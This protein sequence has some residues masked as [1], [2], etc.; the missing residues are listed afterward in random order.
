MDNSIKQNIVLID[1]FSMTSK[2]LSVDNIKCLLGLECVDWEEGN[3]AHGF[4]HSVYFHS[5]KIFYNVSCAGDLF[6]SS[7]PDTILSKDQSYLVWL[8][9]SGS[10]C[11][12]FETFGNGD[13]DGLFRF[14]LSKPEDINI[15]RLDVAFDD[16]T[17]L[18]DI[19]DL[20]DHVDAHY[21]V[22]KFRTGIVEYEWDRLK[23]RDY[24]AFTL[25][26][27]SE[28]S[29]VRIRIYDK[30]KERNI[31]DEHWIRVEMQLRHD[32]AAGFL[33]ELVGHE[34]GLIFRGVLAEYLRFVEPE[35]DSNMRRWPTLSAWDQLL[36]GVAAIN[37][38]VKPG[39]EYNMERLVHFSVDM[40]GGATYTLIK[41]IGVSAFL[42]RLANRVAGADLNPNYKQLLD[43]LGVPAGS[44]DEWQ[45]EIALLRAANGRRRIN[46][47]VFN[48]QREALEIRSADLDQREAELNEAQLLLDHWLPLA[49][50]LSQQNDREG[51]TF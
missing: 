9:M 18:L 6:S 32:N 41:A 28:K 35:A 47:S 10:G 42:D 27:G 38:F 14:C 17:G 2:S 48:K 31:D 46:D 50:S 4:K 43:D 25:Y 15:T 36:D 40:A 5:I 8:D 44:V 20:K 39:I 21:F 11:R 33:R 51:V 7:D 12:A 22:S 37:I 3:G 30:A 16:H 13:F 19:D 1:W 23:S 24:K 34:I 29:D 26:F 45:T 49:R